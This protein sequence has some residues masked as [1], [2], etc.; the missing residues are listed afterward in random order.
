M[1][2]VPPVPGTI[3]PTKAAEVIKAAGAQQQVVAGLDLETTAAG[4]PARYCD[5]IV[6]SEI[7]IDYCRGCGKRK[8]APEVTARSSLNLLFIVF[9]FLLICSAKNLSTSD[10]SPASFVCPRP[11]DL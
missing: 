3:S 11:I 2:G 8:S 4:G 1:A 5:L 10:L 6:W 7:F 9:S